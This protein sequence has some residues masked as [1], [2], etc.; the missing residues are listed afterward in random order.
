M[1]KSQAPDPIL[2][3]TP[4]C[5][6]SATPS[7][8]RQTSCPAVFSSLIFHERD[9]NSAHRIAMDPITMSHGA[10]PGPGSTGVGR[11]PGPEVSKGGTARA[12]P[13]CPFP[14]GPLPAE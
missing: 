3:P 7:P 12:P 6:H 11:Q 8:G 14:G 5:P 10:T 1:K 2:Q 13:L 9:D 4:T